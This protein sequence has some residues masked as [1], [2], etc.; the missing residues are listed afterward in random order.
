MWGSVPTHSLKARALLL[1]LTIWL[2]VTPAVYAGGQPEARLAD[3]EKLIQEQDYSAALKLLAAIQRNDPNLRDKTG[4]LMT[5]IMAVT[6]RYNLVL[7]DLSKAIE[8]EDVEKMLQI[9]PVLHQIDPMRAAG[10]TGQAEVLIGFLKL[11]NRAQGLLREGRTA[12]ALALYLLP[13]TDPGKAGVTLPESQFEGAGYG[14]IITASVKRAIA[15]IVAASQEELKAASALPGALPA[16]KVLLARPPAT[17]GTTQDPAAQ[18]DGIAAPL[19]QAAAAEGRVRI[20]AS[21][22]AEIGRSTQHSSSKGREDLFLRYLQW[23]CLGRASRAEGIAY[24]LRLF[25]VDDAQQMADAAGA[26]VTASFES[27]RSAYESGGL[28]AA[29]A[30]FQDIPARSI[31]AA[32]AAALVSARFSMDAATGAKV[33]DADFQAMKDAL[34]ISLAAQ[35]SAAEAQGYR[36][37]IAYRKDLD[38][39][40]PFPAELPAADA[41]PANLAAESAQLASARASLEHRTAEARSQDDIWTTRAKAWD[42]KADAIDA[43][44]PLAESAR[45]MAALFRSFADTDLRSRDVAY[46]LRIAAIGG[47]SFSKR[48]DDAV[49]MR[50]RAEALNPDAAK[51]Q[52]SPGTDVPVKH[53]DQALLVLTAAKSTLDSLTADIVAHEQKLQA[54]SDSVKANPGFSALFEGTAAQRGYNAILQSAQSETAQID[55]LAA[56]AQSQTDAAA[57]SLIEGDK[58]FK[59]ALD[60]YASGDTKAATDNLNKSLV[61][62][63]ASLKN[64]YSQ[65]AAARSTRDFDEL[66]AKINKLNLATITAG[67]QKNEADI[68]ALINKPDYPAAKDRLD[69]ALA[70]WPSNLGTY[71]PYIDLQQQIQNGLAATQGLTFDRRD[72]RADVV[73]A[74]LNA[75]Q[76]NL[77][78]LKLNEA[79]QNVADA[80]TVAPNY[81][82]ARVLE[83][84]IRRQTD[85]AVFQKAADSEITAYRKLATESADRGQLNGVYLALLS[86]SSLDAT[87]KVQLAPLIQE[88]RYKLNIEP[89][90]AT[91]Q[92]IAQADSLLR[93]A[94]TI[95]QQGTEQ[96]YQQA[97][98]LIAQVSD[99]IKLYPPAVT[100]SQQIAAQ[101]V[102]ATPDRLGAAA[103]ERYNQAWSLYLS[104]AYSDAYTIVQDLWNNTNNQPYVP[105]Q[106]LK[107]RL[108]VALHI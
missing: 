87:F 67:A 25:W 88:L 42:S 18:F 55:V 93:Q 24:A 31:L 56:S 1:C 73:N 100:L 81:G 60:A 10:I 85:P 43:A 105:L 26:A 108:E 41:S 4:R 78:A 64:E 37:L 95:A 98:A 13:L 90:P 97:L 3:A 79:A 76:V 11:M 30:D 94:R 15:D 51:G 96:S 39:M 16:A 28:A 58:L 54:E 40:P 35:E 57:Q 82:A 86:Y 46:A 19:L 91:P 34:G 5:E 74:F 47:A 36:L 92:Q 9:I 29:D 53:P 71:Q 33:P 72:P 70:A 32:K 66:A 69:A 20:G 6:Q 44:P 80:L 7:E 21:S 77:T 103:Q 106:Q 52:V 84:K 107:K 101:R 102:A 12:D 65:Q 59:D 89:R 49:A 2:A 75:S 38:A 63:Q 22:I 17:G 50:T 83:L 27:A 23:L 14:Q 104:G 68:R 61:A 48:L 45:H 99:I 62:Y 8:A